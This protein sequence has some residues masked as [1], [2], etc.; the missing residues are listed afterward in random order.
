MIGTA[1]ERGQQSQGRSPFIHPSGDPTPSTDDINLTERLKAAG[2]LLG[3]PL[4]DHVIVT[5]TTT[6]SLLERALL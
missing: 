6:V 2:E 3:I 1:H 4:L 5:D